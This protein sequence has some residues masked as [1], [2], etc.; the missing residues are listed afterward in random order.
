MEVAGING[1]RIENCTFRDQVLDK[2]HS[3]LTPEAIQIDVLVPKHMNG[4]RC[5]DLPMKNIVVNKCTF[6]NVPRG[7]GSHS[8][9]LNNYVN[10]VTITNNTF[11]NMGSAAIQG[12]NYI[13]CLISDNTIKNS[14]RGIA[15]YTVNTKG[16]YFGSTAGKDGVASST[17]KAYRT[18]PANQNIV[19]TRNV[20]DVRGKEQ[21]T[22]FTNE[23][24]I[25]NG[26]KFDKALKAS[27]ATDA[28]P[29]GDYYASG[30]TITDNTISSIG[31]G[32]RLH[33]ARNSTVAHNTITYTGS[34]KGGTPYY[35]IELLE[36]SS[37]VAVADN[38]IKNV[39]TNGIFI[40]ESGAS[41]VTG[42]KISAP[43]KYGIGLQK[44]S[45]TKIARNSVSKPK[46][47]GIFLSKSSKVKAIDSNTI[48]SS[49]GY[50]VSIDKSSVNSL[51]KNKITSPKNMG[52]MVKA[53]SKVKKIT[54]NTIKSG[55]NRGI[56]IYAPKCA[57]SVTKNKISKCKAWGIYVDGKSKSYKITVKGNKITGKSSV[58]KVKVVSGKVKVSGSKKA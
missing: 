15:L 23:G 32:I 18:P 2:D 21:Y 20:I 45:A 31:H 35:G 1:L 27:S 8:S 30:V 5:E 33:D 26:F 42:N 49:K 12:M 39:K 37:N 24:I 48:S 43:G 56:A 9:I 19:I 11:T 3:T 36:G 47:C 6:T 38:E 7:V 54:G 55:K 17:S 44:G 16:V 40:I 41:S 53:G 14:P 29:K 50:G 13:N 46:T 10:G 58:A 52:I 57:M 28:I 22:S 25:I 34:K 4:Y 51:A